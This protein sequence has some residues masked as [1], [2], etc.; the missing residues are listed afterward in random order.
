M[1]SPQPFGLFVEGD[2]LSEHDHAVTNALVRRVSNL[3]DV[4]G[5]DSLKMRYQLPG[6][7]KLTIINAGGVL[8]ALIVNRPTKRD[9]EQD[10]N[11]GIA[12]LDVPILY[13]GFLP[14]AYCQK[15]DG[16]VVRLTDDTL[17]RLNGYKED[18]GD[19]GGQV[20]VLKRFEV[21]YPLQLQELGPKMP[22]E[23]R[24]YTQYQHVYPTWF[25]GAMKEVVQIVGGWGKQAK[26]QKDDSLPE[27]ERKMLTI[28][29]KWKSKIL[30]ELGGNTRLPGYL[31]RPPV[32]GHI[33]Y[34]YKFMN[35]NGVSFD[36]SGKPWLVKVAP[37]GVWAMPLPMIPA[38]TTKAFKEWM[39]EVGDAEI[40]RIL[41]RFKGIPSGEGFPLNFQAWRRAGVITKVCDASEFFEGTPY[42][43]PC[44][45]AFNKNGTE[46]FAT[47]G[48]ESYDGTRNEGLAYTLNLRMGT[49]TEDG[50]LK[51]QTISFSSP[52]ESVKFNEYM[53]SLY[54]QLRDLEWEGDAEAIKYKIRRHTP[55]ELKA[56]A[57]RGGEADLAYWEDLEMAPIASH[58]GRCNE[59]GRGYL[60]GYILNKNWPAALLF[61][62]TVNN[63]VGCISPDRLFSYPKSE[64]DEGNPRCDTI[65]YGFYDEKDSLKV[66]KYFRE[67]GKS[68]KA[69]ETP[70][71]CTYSGT[72]EWKGPT[73]G[74]AI[75]G[76]FHTTDFDHRRQSDVGY[77]QYKTVGEHLYSSD[78]FVRQVFMLWKHFSAYRHEYYQIEHWETSFD[79][80]SMR[81]AI[82]IPWGF[83]SGYIYVKEEADHLAG[84]SYEKHWAG[85]ANQ[86]R[87]N[88]WT[89]DELGA[90]A[91]T[92]PDNWSEWP[93]NYS[94]VY[95]DEPH[96]ERAG[97]FAPEC[98]PET[99]EDDWEPGT[100]EVSDAIRNGFPHKY[101]GAGGVMD[102][103][104]EPPKWSPVRKVEA[105]KVENERAQLDFGYDGA[106][107]RVGDL[108]VSG[109]FKPYPGGAGG[110]FLLYGTALTFG[111]ASY[112]YINEGNN[113]YGYSKYADRSRV[114]RFIG[115]INE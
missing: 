51:D 72:F 3:K 30:G 10:S 40:L 26:G 43:T 35:T 50:R 76:H 71:A 85:V 58:S 1:H 20:R 102:L 112:T 66:V 82:A 31:G 52:E 54:R 88:Y 105:A 48:K 109:Y 89:Y 103:W 64:E 46:A 61:P 11:A 73:S 17:R 41:D 107:V 44:G 75:L 91:G 49:A 5:I 56:I 29:E 57:G 98:A 92:V 16:L 86:H 87:F 14:R 83:R 115:V 24:T 37:D 27:P 38:T 96:R 23:T 63:E 32:T 34:D 101:K 79:H 53:G 28:P 45:F 7:G 111:D 110:T 97:I 59:T 70:P 12:T 104:H 81:D 39:Q 67:D 8:K 90:W 9:V 100:G 19:S 15:G 2:S 25:T 62:E 69:G 108:P 78:W 68:G 22:S 47:C 65:I 114:P 18:G 36:A 77:S 60:I 113:H 99:E 80:H 93:V 95:H 21:D 84:R 4:S 106:P 6:G 74:S 94:P 13:S 55:S 33:Q 42:S